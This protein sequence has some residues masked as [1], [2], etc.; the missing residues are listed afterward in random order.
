MTG[1]VL[2][3][4]GCPRMPTRPGA[5]AETCKDPAVTILVNH[6]TSHDL[7]QR[8]HPSLYGAVSHSFDRINGRSLRR[9]REKPL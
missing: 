4:G 1:D 6:R 5:S 3:R 8:A 7:R 2:H 9:V